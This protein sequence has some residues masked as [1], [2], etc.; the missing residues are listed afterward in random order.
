MQHILVTGGAGFIGSHLVDKLLEL[1]Y[2][3]TCIDSFDPFYD[4]RQK[5]KNIN[6]HFKN[7]NFT[8]IE[9]NI[10][11]SKEL[12]EKLTDRYDAI[13]HL[14]AKAGIRPSI[15]DPK[16]YTEVNVLGTQHILELARKLGIKQFI[17]GSS[18]SVYGVNPNTPWNEED[19][20]LM[21][22][23]P[24]AATKVAGELLGYTYSHLYDIRFIALRFFTV[25]GPRQRPD[26]AIHKFF[27]KIIK[28]E[29]IDMYGDG[30]TQRDY[31]FVS[32][33]VDGILKTLTYD[34]TNYEIIN[35]G[36]N[37]PTKLADL[38]KYIAQVT[39]TD[40]KINKMPEQPGDVPITYA[41]INKAKKL[42]GYSPKV[43]IEEG[44]QKFNEWFKLNF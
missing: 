43:S 2:K 31:T 41:D 5:R 20:V 15:E 26:L 14:A 1:D 7:P 12:V 40:P 22:I 25:F 8:L 13:I 17:F 10:L 4:P 3:V 38:I 39:G 36:N 18:S 44:L 9:E 29:T 6:S 21:P 27:K 23:S 16:S 35:L 30:S 42:L 24:Y 32:D 34:K 19:H 37:K 28:G 11:N 33:I